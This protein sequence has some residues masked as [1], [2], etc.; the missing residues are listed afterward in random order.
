M[1]NFILAAAIA[2]LVTSAGCQTFDALNDDYTKIQVNNCKDYGYSAESVHAC[3]LSAMKEEGWKIISDDKE[4]GLVTAV[5]PR[6]YGSRPGEIYVTIL[7]EGEA[8]SRVCIDASD[9]VVDISSPSRRTDKAAEKFFK[10]LDQ[11]VSD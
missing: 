5:P 6:S 10:K 7:N 9:S 3:V 8:K 4:T 2:C 1:K 11:L